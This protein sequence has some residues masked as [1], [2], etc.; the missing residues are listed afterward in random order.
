MITNEENTYIVRYKK[1][2]NKEIC[3]KTFKKHFEAYEFFKS[4]NENIEFRAL[5]LESHLTMKTPLIYESENVKN[6]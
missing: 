3:E 1:T 6:K 5:V 2:N 4:L